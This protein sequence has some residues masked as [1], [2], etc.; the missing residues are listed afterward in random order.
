MPECA[1][2]ENPVHDHFV[3][4]SRC[5]SQTLYSLGDQEAHRAELETV[6]AKQ[7]R[8]QP[9]SDGGR[10]ADPALG[11]SQIGDQWLDDVDLDQHPVTYGKAAADCLHAQRGLLVAW[12]RL[13]ADD[14]QAPLPADTVSAMALHLI[15]WLPVLAKHEAGGE[16]VAEIR[17]LVARIYRVIDAPS[18]RS[19]IHVGPCPNDDCPGQVMAVF[20]ADPERESSMFCQACGSAW[21]PEQWH[22][23]GPKIL[24][25]K[26]HAAWS[27]SM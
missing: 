5:Q 19:R 21:R 2:C 13:L 14:M 7:T 9:Q 10:S 18:E 27:M 4:C 16:L 23:V 17:A 15:R 6:L 24:E 12:C 26:V 25:R 11:W 3:I 8:Y 20:P 1:A 22:N